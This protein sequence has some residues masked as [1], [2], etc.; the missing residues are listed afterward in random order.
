MRRLLLASA[1]LLAG[2]S[3]ALAQALVQNWPENLVTSA[4]GTTLA[5]VATL[6][7][8]SGHRGFLCGFSVDA[9]ATAAGVGNITVTGI[10]GGT[11]TF[12]EAWGA[13]G[14]APGYLHNIYT[15]SPCLLSSAISTNIVVTSAAAGSAGV[16]NINAWGGQQ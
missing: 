11:M 10:I 4:A 2:A 16:T 5:T 6:T 9:G 3:S 13:V 7:V 1:F 12:G 15:F 8:P 14:T